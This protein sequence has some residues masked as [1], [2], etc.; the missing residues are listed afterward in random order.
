MEN[1]EIPYSIIDKYF[2]IIKKESIDIINVF[3]KK[4]KKYY[5]L[6]WS[7]YKGKKINNKFRFVGDYLIHFWEYE[8]ISIN[9][10]WKC[11]IAK[12]KVNQ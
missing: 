2:I 7:N 1:S 9:S 4:T 3:T 5:N 11:L 6:T 12:M 10:L 8:L